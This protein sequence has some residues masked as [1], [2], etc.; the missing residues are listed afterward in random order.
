M[1]KSE[2]PPSYEDSMKEDK[3]NE[4]LKLGIKYYEENQ[5]EKAL[6]IFNKVPKNGEANYYLYLIYSNTPLK[7]SDRDQLTI[8]Y[9]QKY[10]KNEKA[11]EY[12]L[13]SVELGYEL[14][15]MELGHVYES[16]YFETEQDYKKA[17]ELYKECK[18]IPDRYYKLANLYAMIYPD[19]ELVK[20]KEYIEEGIKNNSLMCNYFLA[21]KHSCGGWGFEKDILKSKQIYLKCLDM[22]EDRYPTSFHLEMVIGT[23]TGRKIYYHLSECCDDIEERQKWLIMYY[24]NI[25]ENEKGSLSREAIARRFYSNYKSGRDG[26]PE[27]KKLSEYWREKTSLMKKEKIVELF[28]QLKEILSKEE[29]RDFITQLSV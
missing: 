6:E 17:F 11:I 28:N 9:K 15:K 2:E 4:I 29:I 10:N 18:N 12:L 27:D 3:E 20:S 22:L 5:K 14:A 7:N 25:P 16:K 21:H 8:Y 1:A 23:T 24:E 13:K 26:F 19:P